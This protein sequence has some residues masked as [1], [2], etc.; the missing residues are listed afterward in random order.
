MKL[1]EAALMGFGNAAA[2]AGGGSQREKDLLRAI[3]QAVPVVESVVAVADNIQ[4]AIVLPAHDEDAGRGMFISEYAG[5]GDPQRLRATVGLIK[6]YKA[7][8]TGTR[9]E[10]QKRLGSLHKAIGAMSESDDNG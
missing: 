9:D 3:V 5:N 2:A 8:F 10:W 6:G 7:R 1:R 4:S